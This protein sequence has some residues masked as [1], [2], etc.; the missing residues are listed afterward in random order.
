MQEVPSRSSGNTRAPHCNWPPSVSPVEVHVSSCASHS[1]SGLEFLEVTL[2]KH[3]DQSTKFN[4]ILK[5]T[6][7]KNFLWIPIFYN[8]SVNSVHSPLIILLCRFLIYDEIKHINIHLFNIHVNTEKVQN[9]HAFIFN[10]LTPMYPQNQ[11]WLDFCGYKFTF[12]A[13]NES[14]TSFI[15]CIHLLV[16]KSTKLHPHEPLKICFSKKIYPNQFK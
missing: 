12:S 7:T 13:N 3:P 4:I 14:G 8:L 9:Q 5:Q 16:S 10:S 2:S 15:T 1:Q 6:K 11:W